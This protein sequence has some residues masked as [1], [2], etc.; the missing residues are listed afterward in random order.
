MNPKDAD[1]ARLAGTL[2]HVCGLHLDSVAKGPDRS[3][4][5]LR[6]HSKI[7]F[8]PAGDY[9]TYYP[10]T[11]PGDRII[12]WDVRARAAPAPSPGH[13]VQPGGAAGTPPALQARSLDLPRPAAV[14]AN[15]FG[16]RTL[17]L[18]ESGVRARTACVPREILDAGPAGLVDAVMRIVCEREDGLCLK[19]LDSM[20]ERPWNPGPGGQP[21]ADS[22]V[23]F[24]DAANA[25]RRPGARLDMV[26]LGSAGLERLAGQSPGGGK[27]GGAGAGGWTVR[28]HHSLP[29]GVA[30]SIASSGGPALLR[31][32]TVMDCER[33]W[34][35]IRHYCTT[36]AG[37]G[38]VRVALPQG[39]APA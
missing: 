36:E 33:D 14:A 38:G 17:R 2:A 13:A 29:D 31:G 18:G 25:E 26:L 22:L 6:P 15:V 21:G 28:P 12:S 35:V 10:Q 39:G 19:E 27:Q 9:C 23:E 3:D 37:S 11:I 8:M 32:P 24:L 34:F 16:S 7:A 30:Y 4:D 5:P 1:R 20:E